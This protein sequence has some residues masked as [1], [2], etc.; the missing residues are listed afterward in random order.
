MRFFLIL[1]LSVFTYIGFS[2]QNCMGACKPDKAYQACMQGKGCTAFKNCS[3]DAFNTCA[4][5]GC[6]AACEKVGWYVWGNACAPAERGDQRMLAAQRAASCVKLQNSP[7][8]L[9][10]CPSSCCWFWMYPL[11]CASS[12][13]TGP[14]A[15]PSPCCIPTPQ[16]PTCFWRANEQIVRQ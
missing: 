9:E 2:G 10:P 1:I 8:S 11:I 14:Y 12:N 7:D 3:L 13:P 5:L 6:N 16:R 4:G 15:K